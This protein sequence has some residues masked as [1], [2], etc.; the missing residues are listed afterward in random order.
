MSEGQ[1]RQRKDGRCLISPPAE[2]VLF[3]RGYDEG[4]T[5]KPCSQQ[6][7]GAVNNSC[8][9]AVTGQA[10]H[11]NLIQ[12]Q[13]QLSLHETKCKD[14]VWLLLSQTRQLG[15]HENQHKIPPEIAVISQPP[16]ELDFLGTSE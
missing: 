9:R 4:N 14:A 12:D 15:H 3:F 16:G 10:R 11:P 5:V 7:K 13:Q 1:N 2:E 8:G 6:Q